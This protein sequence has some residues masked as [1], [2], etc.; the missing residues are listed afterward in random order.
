MLSFLKKDD[1]YNIDKVLTQINLNDI[2]LSFNQF[3]EFEYFVLDEI[4]KHN[5]I[6]FNHEIKKIEDFIFK[7]DFDENIL[8]SKIYF[9][10][11]YNNALNNK[12]EDAEMLLKEMIYNNADIV[13]INR[14]KF[15]LAFSYQ[16][17]TNYYRAFIY[18]E[19]IILDLTNIERNER[20]DNLLL[21]CY[22]NASNLY[23]RS[24]DTNRA[25]KVIEG[26]KKNKSFYKRSIFYL[27]LISEIDIKVKIKQLS[28]SQALK[29]SLEIENKYIIPNLHFERGYNSVVHYLKIQQLELSIYLNDLNLTKSILDYYEMNQMINEISLESRFNL[30]KIEYLYLI[31]KKEASFQLVNEHIE[32]LKYQLTYNYNF[33]NNIFNRT[34]AYYKEIK[35]FEQLSMF[36]GIFHKL[37][38]EEVEEQKQIQMQL[39]E[40]EFS[41]ENKVRE[42][43]ILNK[44]KAAE[45][46]QIH[47]LKEKNKELE[48][49]AYVLAH[50]IKNPIR[51]IVNLIDIIFAKNKLTDDEKLG[52]I[53]IVKKSSNDVFDLVNSILDYT[54]IE[55]IKKVNEVADFNEVLELCLEKLSSKIISSQANIIFDKNTKREVCISHNSLNKILLNL[56][57]NSIKFAKKD[58]APE[59]IITSLTTKEYFEFTI[60]DNGVGIEN[61][62]QIDIFK[63]FIKNQEN[64]NFDGIGLG[65]AICQKIMEVYNGE[66]IMISTKNEGSEFLVRIPNC[67]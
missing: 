53:D 1:T 48:R 27:I 3:T 65:L 39:I 25:L 44:L 50:D 26:A 13:S 59:I 34:T 21:G 9:L 31:N 58:V 54:G 22:I 5:S 62:T 33:A 52:M 47:L 6:E 16:K 40:A 20:E 41:L 19:Q 4:K 10:K 24:N 8:K 32:S 56:I 66:I 35:D 14:S 7:I 23:S 51:H 30:C 49:F 12:I 11:I 18:Y 67:I 38:N 42:I 37:T 61:T 57:D 55:S 64:L 43:E 60:K 29:D 15:F 2:E 45:E 46:N 17:N 36:L 28:Y 63:S